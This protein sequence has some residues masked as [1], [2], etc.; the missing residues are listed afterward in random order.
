[1]QTGNGADRS[2]Q[3]KLTA[4]GQRLASVSGD[5]RRTAHQLH[6]SSLDHLGL[7]AA[8]KSY[9]LEF[10]QHEG[11]LVQFL[12][13][14]VPA[15]IPPQVALSLYRSAQEALRNV[16]L[17]SGARR[18]TVSLTGRDE[19][20]V[21]SVKDSGRGFDPNRVKGR[22]LGLVSLDERARLMGAKVVLKT[23]PGEGVQIQI[24]APLHARRI[25]SP[26]AKPSKSR[27]MSG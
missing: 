13:R 21:L 25:G 19:S 22:G 8:L 5:I 17:H 26:V 6:P 15:R 27:Q 9:C 20:I 3:R 11:I 2:L 12:Q 14:N 23:K 7:A 10:S 4:L 16:A 24:Q 18:A 1:L